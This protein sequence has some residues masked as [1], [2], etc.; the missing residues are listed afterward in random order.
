M[1]KK[2][3]II[4]PVWNR[5]TIIERSIK[6]V[7]AQDFKDY[8]LLIID[9]GSD[10]NLKEVVQP[11]LSDN[12]FYYRIAHQGASVA[13]NVGLNKASGQYIAYLDSDNA[14]YPNFLK[15]MY[16]TLHKTKL[17]TC[18]AYC[19]CKVYKK[20]GPSGEMR[21]W[22]IG[23]KFNYKKLVEENYIDLNTFVHSKQCVDRVGLFE[24]KLKRFIDWEFILRIT[25]KY[26]PIFINEV[27][28]D[29]YMGVVKNTI[30]QTEDSTGPYLMIKEKYLIYDARN[31]TVTHDD[32]PYQWQH[33]SEKKYI[34][35]LKMRSVDHLNT[36]DYFAHGY[37]Y[38]LQIE[39]TNRCNLSCTVCPAAAGKNDLKR[40]RRDMKLEEFTSIIDNMRDYLLV[41]VLWDWGE[42]FMHPQLPEM[43]N[44]ATG[45]DIRV[46]TSTNAH[47]LHNLDYVERI[48]TSGLSTLIV[49][50][51]SLS[52]EN[53]Q[54]YRQGGSLAKAMQGLEN[55]LKLKKKLRSKTLINLRMVI[56]KTNEHELP[57]MREL[58]QRLK[59]DKFT[60]KTANPGPEL[61]LKD[62]DIVPRNPAYRRYLYKPGTFQRIRVDEPCRRVWWI[63]NIFSNGDVVPCC[64][65]YSSE[66]KLGNVFEHSFTEIWQ[67]LKY[68][69]FRKITFFE[70]DQIP[71]CRDCDV[72]YKLSKNGW[73]IETHDFNL[74]M[75]HSI[76]KQSRA[77]AKRVLPQKAIDFIRKI[78]N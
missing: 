76:M 78:R 26:P 19:K 3:S 28:V 67:G 18:V 30:T 64:Y 13:R 7:L 32:I 58:A 36:T 77:L 50:I 23:E 59:V 66:L 12:V 72:N 20:Y 71:K 39:P 65:D 43:I 74:G 8:E 14:W 42:P 31:I 33:V 4:M 9:D 61:D 49:A 34:N 55:L 75:P 73:F 1:G 53:Y 62:E 56:M 5:A 63:S 22:L 25:L 11:F 60:V 41:V 51:D 69:N 57:A 24:E 15:K 6:S 46:V 44:Y 68:R 2:F 29:Y 70:K 52:E 35:W 17:K 38:L 37:P 16:K 27:L 45:Q 54:K 48:L 47:F 40:K 21:T 10:D